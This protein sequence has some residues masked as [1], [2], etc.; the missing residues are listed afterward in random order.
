MDEDKA[1]EKLLIICVTIFLTVSSITW[2]MVFS[3]IYSPTSPP[4]TLAEK[5]LGSAS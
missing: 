4:Q 5:C 2:A 1:A 3:S